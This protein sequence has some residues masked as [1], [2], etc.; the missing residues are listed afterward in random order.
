MCQWTQVWRLEGIAWAQP[1]SG[2]WGAVASSAMLK[3]TSLSSFPRDVSSADLVI[4]NHQGI[5]AEVEARTDSFNSCIAMGTA[6]L[7]KGHYASDKVRLPGDSP[8]CP[9]HPSTAP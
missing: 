6:L 1:A 7:D 4:K 3:G 9:C 2:E 8:P 5:K